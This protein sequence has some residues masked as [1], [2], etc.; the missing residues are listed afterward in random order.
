[1]FLFEK[2]NAPLRGVMLC[3]C[4]SRS[5]F[6]IEKTNMENPIVTR[7]CKTRLCKTSISSSRCYFYSRASFVAS[8][9]AS[10]Q[11]D[12]FERCYLI[13][14]SYFFLH[15]SL[16]SILFFRAS[17]GWPRVRRRIFTPIRSR[18]HQRR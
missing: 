9:R 17:T 8:S 11:I 14:T 16:D 2:N 12:P 7:F 5:P 3:V 1:M 6:K 4:S 10:H 15:H 13:L 18:P